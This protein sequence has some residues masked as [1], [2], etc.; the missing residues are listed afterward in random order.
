MALYFQHDL[1]ELLRDFQRNAQKFYHDGDRATGSS[2]SSLIHP[3]LDLIEAKVRMD[4]IIM[5]T[6]KDA[7]DILPLL[8][9]SYIVYIE[10]PGFKKE[11]LNISLDN[12]RLTVTGTAEAD[13]YRDAQDGDKDSVKVK[14]GERQFGTF[15]RSIR[16]PPGLKHEDVKASADNGILRIELP[17]NAPQAA[18]QQITIN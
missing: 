12:D 4:T 16:V 7:A 18:K 15:T 8:Q 1:S 3:K 10:V 2:T 17:K 5:I 9:D 13:Y 6:S 14:V 11:A